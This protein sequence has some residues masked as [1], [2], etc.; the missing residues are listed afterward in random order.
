M[1]PFSSRREIKECIRYSKLVL[2]GVISFQQ[3]I[4]TC[5]CAV[6]EDFAP[7][8]YFFSGDAELYIPTGHLS[9]YPSIIIFHI[10]YS[11]LI[12]ISKYMVKS[13]HHKHRLFQVKHS[14]VVKSTL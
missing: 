10:H 14:R 1:E 6:S 13:L 12:G 8:C 5:L 11:C 7:F 2:I 3:G 9:I 4:P